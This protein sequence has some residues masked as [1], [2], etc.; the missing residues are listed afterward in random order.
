MILFIQVMDKQPG[1]KM[2]LHI[3]NIY[4][5]LRSKVVTR[6]VTEHWTLVTRVIIDTFWHTLTRRISLV[7]NNIFIRW[8]GVSLVLTYKGISVTWGYV[9]YGNEL[10]LL[11]QFLYDARKPNYSRE[12]SYI[13]YVCHKQKIQKINQVLNLKISITV[14][15]YT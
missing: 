9:C 5:F 8:H 11:N 7:W 4:N 13:L 12:R 2:D 15:H 3:G 14:Q 1:K 6:G 10:E